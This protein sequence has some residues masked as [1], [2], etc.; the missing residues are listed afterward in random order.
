MAHAAALLTEPRWARGVRNRDGRPV[1]LF[2][3]RTTGSVVYF[4]DVQ[5]CSCPSYQHR[6]L[7]AHVVAVRERD[8]AEARENGLASLGEIDV[9]FSA[10]YAEAQARDAARRRSEL[11]GRLFNGED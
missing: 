2:A 5:F 11:L 7:C 10:A 3:S 4:A 9:A 1:F 8:E 6:G